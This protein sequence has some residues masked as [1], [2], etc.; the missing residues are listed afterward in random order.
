MRSFLPG[1]E[2]Q[3]RAF[4]EQPL[5]DNNGYRCALAGDHPLQPTL[6]TSPRS[7]SQKAQYGR[8][9]YGDGVFG[10]VPGELDGHTEGCETIAFR[11]ISSVCRESAGAGSLF[12]RIP[13]TD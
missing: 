7:K 13:A 5:Q 11:W 1:G 10:G 8:S 12:R 3:A 9:H 4:P 6:N 2:K